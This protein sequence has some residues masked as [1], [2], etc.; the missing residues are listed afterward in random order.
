MVCV[1]GTKLD[2]RLIRTDWDP[3]FVEGRQFGRGRS[4]G[5]V[6]VGKGGEWEGRLSW[7]SMQ[8]VELS[9]FTGLCLILPVLWCGRYAMSSGRTMMRAGVGL[10][11][12]IRRGWTGD[13]M[14]GEDTNHLVW[15]CASWG[16]RVSVQVQS[17]L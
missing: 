5:Q 8:L 3:G 4:G 14:H 16:T 13:L 17:A 10:A 1:N 6:S 11:R 7:H 9:V 12:S 15:L 2:D